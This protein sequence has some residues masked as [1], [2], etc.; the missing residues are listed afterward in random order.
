[1]TTAGVSGYRHPD[2][3]AAMCHIGAPRALARSGGWL[4]ERDIPGSD[5]YDLTGCY[6]IFS[7]TDW[8][9]LDD[10]IAELGSGP[11][12]VS[13]VT[14][15]F[16]RI[17]PDRLRRSFPDRC[18]PYKE[19]FVTDLALPD[20]SIV[21][22]HHRRNVRRALKEIDVEVCADADAKVHLEAWTRLYD[23][24]VARHAIE[25]AAA[26][27]EESF[28]RQFDV[29]GLVLLR[30]VHAGETAGITLWYVQDDVAYYH[31]GAY[32]EAGYR[33]GA[34]FALFSAAL[35]HFRGR[36]RWLALGAGAGVTNDGRDGLT[37]FKR[38]W[39]TGTRTVYFCGR[40]LDRMAYEA[41]TAGRA[42]DSAHGI[43]FFPAYRTP[44]QTGAA[45][46]TRK[47]P[48]PE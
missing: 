31:L 15:P 35:G 34:A 28:R 10:D 20:Q 22:A 4:L 5:R 48:D 12:S 46:G 2:Y 40:V 25:G 7:C 19:H 27:P 23:G 9:N 16:A 1:M 30:A 3:A 29:P 41:L 47:S 33:Q 17:D 37:R 18:I 44:A 8:D 43:G 24:L 13:L 6:P 45:A 14:D 11:V 36:V 39:A 21:S 32:D 42:V 26:F 38:G